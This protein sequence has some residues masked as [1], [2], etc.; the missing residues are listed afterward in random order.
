MFKKRWGAVLTSHYSM[1]VYDPSV[2][3]LYMVCAG[4]DISCVPSGTMIKDMIEFDQL[5]IS[6]KLVNIF[7]TTCAIALCK[8]I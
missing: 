3:T 8:D 1:H 4:F 2:Y 7:I 6:K 5:F